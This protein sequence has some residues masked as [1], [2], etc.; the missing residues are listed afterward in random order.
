MRRDVL[1]NWKSKE[2]NRKL[3]ALFKCESGV[4]RRIRGIFVVDCN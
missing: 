2:N 4:L 3:G 1:K